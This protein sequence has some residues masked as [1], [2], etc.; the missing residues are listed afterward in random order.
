[1][2]QSTPSGGSTQWDTKSAPSYEEVSATALAATINQ[3]T[4]SHGV[5]AT[6]QASFAQGVGTIGAKAAALGK[7]TDVITIEDGA[8]MHK[9]DLGK[10]VVTAGDTDD[11]LKNA[12]QAGLDTHDSGAYTVSNDGG[13]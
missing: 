9:F 7:G 1:M 8:G 13:F 2:G 3:D 4:S 12:I 11:K 5:T 6:A 10:V